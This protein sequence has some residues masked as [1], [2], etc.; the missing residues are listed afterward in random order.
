MH[1]RTNIDNDTHRHRNWRRV[2][3][4]SLALFAL[5]FTLLALRLMA[6]LDPSSSGSTAA[7]TSATPSESADDDDESF[8]AD[9]TTSPA[10]STSAS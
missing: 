2:A 5:V 9:S 4:S 8:S 7:T 6:G 10:P 1:N 3:F